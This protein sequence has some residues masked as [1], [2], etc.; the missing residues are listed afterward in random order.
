MMNSNDKQL[1]NAYSTGS[2]GSNFENRVQASFVVLMLT[3]G[4]SPCL[5]TWPIEEIKLQ[6]KYQGFDT[7]DLIIFAKHSGSDRQAK[8]L[9]QIKHSISIT[10]RDKVFGEV[11][12]AAWNDFNNKNLFNERTDVLALITGPLSS[13][14]TINV[15]GLLNQAHYS[16]NATDFIERISLAIFT[17]N[18]QREKLDVFRTHLKNANKNKEVSD[19]VLWRFLKCFNLL[20]YD[21]DIKG[22]TLSLLHTLIGQYSQKRAEDLLAL[23][24]KEVAYRNENASFINMQSI[25]ENIRSAF[26]EKENRTIPSDLLKIHKETHEPNWNTSKFGGDLIMACLI[27]SWS[28]KS[29]GDIEIIS[30]FAAMDFTEWIS[31]FQ[32]ILQNTESPVK[33]KNG[34]WSVKNRKELFEAINQRIYDNT[35]KKFKDCAITVLSE[36]DPKFSLPSD[37]RFGASLYGKDLKFS[38]SIREGIAE[39]IALLGSYEKE[40]TNCSV[41]HETIVNTIV[42]ELYKEPDWKLWGSLDNLLPLIAEASPEHFLSAVE[43]TLQQDPCPF[44]Q[45]FKQESEGLIGG[46]YLS[47]LLWAL[48]TI[49]WD[50]KYLVRVT[51]ALGELAYRDP[52]GFWSNR[53]A[54]SLTTIY[55]PWFPQTL[56]T[57]EKRKVA[58]QTLIKEVPT[59][60]WTLLISLLPNQ[61]QTSSGSHKPKWRITIPFEET[62]KIGGKEYWEQVSNYCE[63]AVDMSMNNLERLSELVGYLNKLPADSFERI[64]HIMLSDNITS[65]PETE[66]IKLWTELVNFI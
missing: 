14:D 38:P 57:I 12:Q 60:G 9:G 58:V 45:L 25:P 2:G 64:L 63:L 8:L 41:K 35:L 22:V 66:R 30:K 18:G 7:D 6:G 46:N 51:I 50:E 26:K 16:K 27:G 19:E 15:R 33:F 56:S 21:L 49:A 44:D 28:E 36:R 3:G 37:Q 11:I 32:E 65:K 4:F 34:I 13:K 1:S 59:V 43:E 42:H 54:N 29:D 53:P 61:F 55:L 24:E 20:L 40:L 17:S 5:P 31:K 47:G 10:K 52:G 62:N 23:I 48:E 39:G